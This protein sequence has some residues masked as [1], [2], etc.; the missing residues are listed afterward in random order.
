M[1]VVDIFLFIFVPDAFRRFNEYVFTT[2]VLK[3][4]QKIGIENTL[5]IY[6]KCIICQAVIC[7]SIL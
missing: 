6:F 3:A 2:K 7:S 5:F 4:R 1:F